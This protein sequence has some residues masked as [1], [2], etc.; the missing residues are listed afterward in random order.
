M[1]DSITNFVGCVPVQS[2][3]QRDL[4]VC[5]L[6]QF[7]QVLGHADYTYLGENAPAARQM[8]RLAVRARQ[9][10]GLPTKDKNRAAYSR[11]NPLCE[12]QFTE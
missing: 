9:A 2:K 4:R 10:L 3:S 1:V 11:G 12:T 5:K 8:Q 6:L 7:T